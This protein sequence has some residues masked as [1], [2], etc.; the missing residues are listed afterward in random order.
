MKLLL[1]LLLYGSLLYSQKIDFS[2]V[3]KNSNYLSIPKDDTT[4]EKTPDKVIES[5]NKM[6]W[7]TS[8]DVENTLKFT[9]TKN[10]DL[11]ILI[12]GNGYKKYAYFLPYNHS[13]NTVTNNPVKINLRWS[14]NNEEGFET[15]LLNKPLIETQQINNKTFL[16]LKERVHNGNMYNAVVTKVFELTPKLDMQLKFCFEEVSQLTFEETMINRQFSKNKIDSFINGK[17]IGSVTIDIEKGV[18]INSK[19]INN[20]YCNYLI[21]SSGENQSDFLKKGYEVWY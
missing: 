1:T 12:T 14:Y 3:L 2:T 6:T 21:K 5:I 11:Y 9:I 8:L 10:V 15:K 4:I 13:K 20:D 17:L 19:C 7:E 18:I 16:L